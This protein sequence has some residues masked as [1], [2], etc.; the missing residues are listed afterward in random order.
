MATFLAIT[1][2]YFIGVGYIIQRW[3]DIQ[4][5]L[6]DEKLIFK[7]IFIIIML[8][9]LLFSPAHILIDLGMKIYKKLN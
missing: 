8:S 6:K 3:V 2:I 5:E 7:I 1:A 4:A 9:S